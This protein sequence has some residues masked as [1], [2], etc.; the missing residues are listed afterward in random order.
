MTR[1]RGFTLLEL[2]L[3]M[4]M[5]AMV[6]AASMVAV[7]L[8]TAADRTAITGYELD[9]EVQRALRLLQDDAHEAVAITTDVR[10]LQFERADG[11][12]V[13]WLRPPGDE[14]LHRLSGDSRLAVD[15]A[16]SEL[17]TTVL[18]LKYDTR[19]RLRDDSYRPTAALQGDHEFSLQT[20]TS[21]RNGTVVGIQ[22]TITTAAGEKRNRRSLTACSARLVE[23]NCKP[24][25]T[26]SR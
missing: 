17:L 23:A 4:T 3:A 8:F 25:I 18:P 9:T 5:T 12:Y 14:E 15:A 13:T 21:W 16:A 6:M 20:V 26:T 2:L 19:G 11:K 1:S 24:P 10:S 22:A 7:D